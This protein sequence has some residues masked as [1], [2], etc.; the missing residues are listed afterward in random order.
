[1]K[2]LLITEKNV[3][4]LVCE[5]G[6]IFRPSFSTMVKRIRKGQTQTFEI[7][8]KE[9]KISPWVSKNGYLVV[10]AKVGDIRP[11]CFV[12]RL[13][14]LAF[15]PGYKEGLVVNHINGNKLDNRP[16]NLEWVTVER[17]SEHAWETNL[18]DL[19]G[20]KQP[21]HVL[22]EKQ[23]IHIRQALRLGVPANSL[24]IIAKVSPSIIHLISKNKRWKHIED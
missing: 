6:S 19:R 16:E 23:V 3:D 15:V 5:D 17:N 9:S 14:A 13:I 12:H 8:K 22:S 1:M 10:S 2:K 20:E 21:N 18:V 24:S 11:K 4:W 7:V